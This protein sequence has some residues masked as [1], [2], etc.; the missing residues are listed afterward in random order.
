MA[1]GIMLVLTIALTTT[2]YL[3]SS[4]ARHAYLSNAGQKS[5]ALAESG[6]NNAVAVLEANYPGTKIYPGDPN[7]LL[8]T[9]LTSPVTTLPASTTINVASTTGY[10][11]GS[12]T[13]S[14]GSSG[15]VTCTGITS[16]T[17]T[18][19]T[20]GTAGTYATGTTVARATAAGANSATWSG[21]LVNVPTNPSW[22]WQWQLT[23]FGRVKNP[24]GPAADVV[25]RATAVVPVVI[26]DSTFATPARRPST[27]STDS[28]DV[29]FSQSVNVASPVYAVH[30]I[31]SRTPR[32]SPRR[33]RRRSRSP[34]AEQ[35]R[36]RS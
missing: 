12:N 15:A 19:C 31:T 14:V 11:S 29:N 13:I 2:I 20:G 23:A 36:G 16:T 22:K 8:S 34:R 33:S 32:R 30:D 17:F 28:N 5:Y 3:T 7:L 24:T 9:T 27:G 35:G 18:G 6:I 10:N 4:S 25:R 21:T 1:L 26:P